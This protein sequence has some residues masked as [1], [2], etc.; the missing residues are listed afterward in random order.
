M[1]NDRTAV[2]AYFANT[3]MVVSFTKGATFNGVINPDYLV[4]HSAP[5]RAVR[6]IV[7]NFNNVSLTR[8]GLLIPLAPLDK[9]N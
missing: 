9:E 1:D 8:D 5:T 6:E 2:F 7:G 3:R 4:V